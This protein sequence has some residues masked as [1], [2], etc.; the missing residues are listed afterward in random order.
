MSPSSKIIELRELLAAKYPSF[1][2]KTAGYLPTGVARVDT[3]LKGGLPLG[4]LTEIV[5]RAG[6]GLLLTALARTTLRRS[7]LMALIDCGDAFDP[8]G[9]P[10]PAL[11]RLLWIRKQ[12]AVQAVQSADL[13]LHDGNLNLVVLDLCSTRAEEIRK[14]PASSWYRLQRVVESASTAFVVLTR[15]PLVSGARPRL[16]LTARFSLTALECRQADLLGQIQVS[17]VRGQE[18]FLRRSA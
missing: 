10:P 8:A 17:L 12:S 2:T 1:P 4:G 6:G 7:G 14:V 15:E 3:V 16:E 11:P 5:C 9:V 18:E 13:L